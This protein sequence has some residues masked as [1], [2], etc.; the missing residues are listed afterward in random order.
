MPSEIFGLPVH[1]LLVHATVVFVP[2]AVVL[3]IGAV[4]VP[5]FRAWAGPLP[6]AVSLVALILTPLSTATGETLEHDLPQSALIERHAELGDQLLP[7]TIALFVL[8]AG[9]WWLTRGGVP[10]SRWPRP[11]VL[12]VGALAIVAA[13]GT[14]VQVARIGHS[15][16]EAAWSDVGSPSGG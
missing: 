16:A 3:V 6:A 10:E 5:R 15:G 2:L 12:A 8:A 7:F 9:F 11:L 4:L 14:S 13:V 1:P